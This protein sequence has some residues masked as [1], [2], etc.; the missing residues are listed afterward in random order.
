MKIKFLYVRHGE[1]IFNVTN[2]SQ[3]A[4]DSPLTNNGIEQAKKCAEKLSS[5]K[6]D[7]C[8]CSTSERAIDTANIILHDRNIPI[9]T[10][11]GLK[12][13]FFGMLEGSNLTEKN[14]LME[15]CWN[16]KDFTAYGG[17]NRKIFEIRIKNTYQSIV[18]Q[19]KDGDTILVVSHRGYFNYMLESLFGFNLEYLEKKNPKYLETLIPNASEYIL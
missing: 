9:K 11:K 4:C 15:Q 1:T 3:G 17:E 2:K 8:Y 19:S 16:N 5:V 13:M 12:E 6:I 7:K 10:L 14:S 18:N